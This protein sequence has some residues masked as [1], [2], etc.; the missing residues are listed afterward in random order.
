M[1]L[2]T[3]DLCAVPQPR[4]ALLSNPR[5]WFSLLPVIL[6]LMG[7]GFA[8]QGQD[9]LKSMPGYAQYEKMS[10][11]IPNSVKLG[12]LSVTWVE[13]GRALDYS[14]EGKRYRYD[15]PTRSVGETTNRAASRPA[16]RGSMT[17]RGRFRSGERPER[18]RQFTNSVSP[19]GQWR[20]FYRDRN[21]WLGATNTDAAKA[22][23]VTT[24]GSDRSRI[25]YGSANW[26]YGE[27]LEQT[28]AMWWSSNSQKLAFY[29]FDESQVR[30]YYGTLDETR[31]QNRLDTEPYMKVGATNPTVDLLVYDLKTRKTT[32]LDV[33]DGRPFDNAVIG[34]YVYGVEWS[35]NGKELLFHR[36]NRRQN[37][38][39]FCAGD[40]QTGKCRVIVREEWMPSW[41]ENLPPIYWLQ[42]GRR[43]LWTSERSGWR[44]LY[45]YDLDHGLLSTV[46]AH[47]FEVGEIARVDEAAGLVYYTARSGDNPLKL[48]LH[49]VTLDGR[50]D[51]RLT[52]PAFHHRVDLAPDGQHFVDIAET[53]DTPPTSTLL[54]AEGKVVAALA[55]S[56]LTKFKQLGLKPVELLHFQAADGDTELY[57]ML[58]FPST[59]NPRKK[60]PLLVSVYA[61]PATTG[62]RETFTL[63]EALTEYGFLVATFDSRSASGRGKQFLDAIYLR[64]GIVEVDDQ[65]AGVKSLWNRRYVDRQRVGIFG[66]SYG[67]TSSALCLLRYPD[68]FQAANANS[69]VTDFRN[70]DTIYAERYMWIPEENRAGFEAASAMTYATNLQGR[71]LV[72][73]GTADNNVHPSNALQ[74]IRALQRAGK[75]FEVQVGPDQGHTGVN[76]ERMMEFFIQSLVLDKPAEP[77]STVPPMKRA[78]KW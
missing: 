4:F 22:T 63:P 56:D 10:K 36:T 34:H 1:K 68:V 48:Q 11:E 28:T 12:G 55:A 69:A 18:G 37:I 52:D 38:M 8:A 29:R 59:F 32:R 24:D 77:K 49:R 7:V 73:Y 31:W 58:H 57:G 64:L 2:A 62:A 40:P 60:Y 16:A 33:R 61:G 9:R 54:D 72:Y 35:Q 42:D 50:G 21:V 20:A 44:N 74:L 41:T 19:D 70:Y 47:P 15:I 6:G 26:V 53:H 23:A 5:R 25:K 51:R 43:F 78:D 45:L 46:T 71:L 65:A 66:T 39:E 75:S 27:E 76:R 13:E 14:W 17:R 3:P 67:G 30:D